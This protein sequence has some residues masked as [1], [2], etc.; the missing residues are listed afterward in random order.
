MKLVKYN[1]GMQGKIGI[2]LNTYKIFSGKYFIYET[3]EKDKIKEFDCYTDALIYE[4]GY[5]NGKRNGKGKEYY[6]DGKL[7]FEGEY[8]NGKRNG[9]GKEYHMN[10][11]LKFE[12]VYLDGKKWNGQGYA[13]DNE[14]IYKLENGKG[15]VKQYYEKNK[16][17]FKEFFLI[18]SSKDAYNNR[19]QFE[20]EYLNGTKN[21]KGK[22][23]YYN[24]RTLIFEGEYLDGKKWN[25]K[26]Y[27]I[28]KNESYDIKDGKGFV[29]ILNNNETLEYEGE[30]LN[31]KK[32]G[33]GKGN[34]FIFRK[35]TKPYEEDEIDMIKYEG[36]YLNGK[37]NGK[38]KELNRKDELMF[39]GV[40]YNDHKIQGKAYNKG[41]LEYEGEYL[42]DKKW[43]G[44]GYNENG[45]IIYQLNNGTGKIKEY[46]LLDE[47]IFEGEYLNGKRSGK[48]KEY[49]NN[50]KIKYEG[51]YINGERKGKSK[52]Y[53]Q[54][55]EIKF[56]G[57]YLKGRKWNGKIFDFEDSTVI[58]ELKDGKGYINEY[59]N[60]GILIFEGEYLDGERDGKGREYDEYEGDLMFEGE[61]L[62]GKKWNGIIKEY[63]FDDFLFECELLNGKKT[64][65][66]REYDG[67]GVL[68]F[69][70]EYLNGERNRKGTI[71]DNNGN[72]IFVGEYENGKRKN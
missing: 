26:I 1:R 52:E 15:L 50:G 29:K 72:I 12:G 11:K 19:L 42:F 16:M 27:D 30:Y 51:E 44:N 40:F 13:L 4:G 70:G 5:L 53:Y 32:N 17:L 67:K 7:K 71:Y 48:G 14:I 36:E 65:K 2:N 62:K 56:E 64:G 47:F 22:E 69:E 28:S 10:E 58:Y 54:N 8:L 49:Y 31:G 35:R 43:S 6:Y 68:K 61:Y 46:N 66:G 60:E 21:G 23:Y 39:E 18:P 63:L 34:I 57:E 59:N 25:G 9:K 55:G 37:R 38:G 20:G 3:K 33:N 24:R 41:I 45:E